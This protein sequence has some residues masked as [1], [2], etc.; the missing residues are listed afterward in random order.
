[1]LLSGSQEDDVSD[2]RRLGEPLHHLLYLFGHGVDHC[3]RVSDLDPPEI[4]RG[5]IQPELASVLQG[6]GN[7]D[8][9]AGHEVGRAALTLGD[10]TAWNS[11][12]TLELGPRA[13]EARSSH[14]LLGPSGGGLVNVLGS[15]GG[16]EHFAAGSQ[17]HSEGVPPWEAVVLAFIDDNGVVASGHH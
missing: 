9:S 14:G 6:G 5:V 7:V 8:I 3:K 15:V 13:A 1:D 17:R 4:S 12:T 11:V 16:Q 10:Q 2:C